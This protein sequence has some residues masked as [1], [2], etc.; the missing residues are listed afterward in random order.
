[1]KVE[2]TYR[3][4][5]QIAWPII[6]SS[7]ANTIINFTDVAFVARVGEKQLAA[8]ALGGIFYFVMVMT[9]MAI[10]I[11]SQILISRKA[12]E[13]DAK[14]IG[15]IFDHSLLILLSVA[16]LIEI[17]FYG[18]MPWLMNAI[19]NDPDIAT[20]SIEYLYARGWGL[21]FMMVLISLRCFYTGIA[22]TRIISYTTMLMMILNI[23]LNYCFVFGKFGFPQLGIIG[24]GLASA[25]S[26]MMASVYAVIYALVKKEFRKFQLFKFKNLKLQ[27]ARSVMVI[28]APIVLQQIVSMGAW[29]I[30]F[31]LIEKMGSRELAVSNVVRSVYMVLM[32]P[33][34]GYSQAANAM[35]SNLIGQGRLEEVPALTGKI[36]RLSFITGSLVVMLSLLFPEFLFGLS[37]SDLTMVEDAKYSYYIICLATVIFSVSMVLLSAVSGT[38]QTRVAMNIELLNIFVYLVYVYICTRVLFTGVE[39]VWGSEILYWFLMGWLSRV[40]LKSGKWKKTLLA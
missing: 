3:D 39:W 1:M 28:S 2:A 40:Y 31:L 10:G 18:M 36:I 32:T 21:F 7:L 17:M 11:G 38:G 35:V 5:W 23:I 33:I 30:F 27:I 6:I 15:V 20:Y 12:G 29:F 9:G 37:T 14:G 8:A 16:A 24:V 22:T 26:E 19:I 13:N 4:I 25:I 34:W